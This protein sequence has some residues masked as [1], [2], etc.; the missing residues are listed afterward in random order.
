MTEVDD[1]LESHEQQQ[2]HQK[3]QEEQQMWEEHRKQVKELER[4][5]DN[6]KHG[7]RGMRR[8]NDNL[9]RSGE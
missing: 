4:M 2:W 5:L 9:M 6:T 8:V 1:I 3:Q 7:T